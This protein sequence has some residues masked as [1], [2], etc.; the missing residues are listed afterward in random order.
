MTYTQ[1]QIERAARRIAE[2]RQLDWSYP[3]VREQYLDIATEVA[4]ELDGGE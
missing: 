4:R 2:A 1:A 3:Y